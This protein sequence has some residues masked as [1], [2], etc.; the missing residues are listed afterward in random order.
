ML[1]THVPPTSEFAL[2]AN[3]RDG[4]LLK[5]I[6]VLKK[7]H[8]KKYYKEWR[9][10][11]TNHR[12]EYD[13][14][15]KKEYVEKHK[16][17]IKI[18][19]KE[20]CQKNKVA[21]RDKLREYRRQHSEERKSKRKLDRISNPEK[22]KNWQDIY[23][24][25]NRDHYLQTR[26][27]WSERNPEKVKES[28]QKSYEKNYDKIIERNKVVL[29]IRKEV[30][31]VGTMSE[32]D[33]NIMKTSYA[34]RCVRCLKQV[35]EIKITIDHII[36]ISLGGEHS[37]NNVQPLCLSCNAKKSNRIFTDYRITFFTRLEMIL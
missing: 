33:W 24:E 15:Y 5:L 8:R 21:I 11:N 30:Y 1:G 37:W 14:K 3:L 6:K 22:H 27:E 13:R 34:E 16:D 23:R 26:R 32:T 31:E 18:K 19:R 9:L 12:K 2:N 35:P 10:K 4:I 28:S 17:E 25:R 36:P 7:I 29:K 20:Y